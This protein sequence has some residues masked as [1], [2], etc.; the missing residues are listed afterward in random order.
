MFLKVLVAIVAIYRI[1]FVNT[2]N[3]NKP[4]I[5][6]EAQIHRYYAHLIKEEPVI[7]TWVLLTLFRVTS[8]FNEIRLFLIRRVLIFSNRGDTA[9]CKTEDKNLWINACRE[10]WK[11]LQAIK[12]Y[13]NMYLDYSDFSTIRGEL[14]CQKKTVD[15]AKYAEI[16]YKNLIV[17]DTPTRLT[18]TQHMP[19]CYG[20]FA[21]ITKDISTKF[22][23]RLAIIPNAN[24]QGIIVLVFVKNSSDRY[25]PYK[26]YKDLNISYDN[27]DRND[28][29]LTHSQPVSNKTKL[30]Y[31]LLQYLP[32][33]EHKYVFFCI[34]FVFF[35]F[36]FNLHF[37]SL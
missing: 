5:S 24:A 13:D 17:T 25:T 30:T 31:K 7:L 27:K 19:I 3:P 26:L 15:I 32:I 14:K 20:R 16:I 4:I 6:E 2:Y 12:R 1:N 18:I 21:K 33:L 11:Q 9:F 34:H 23:K 28:F 10:V 35:F 22:H 36:F 37:H 29:L 8:F